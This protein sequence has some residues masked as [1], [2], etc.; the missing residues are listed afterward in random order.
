[1]TCGDFTFDRIYNNE[2]TDGQLT[3]TATQ[4]D[5]IDDVYTPGVYVVTITGTVDEAESSLTKAT[6]IEIT[7]LDPCDPPTSVTS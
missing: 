2:S 5:Y 6:I 1:M 7:L 3:F 4:Q